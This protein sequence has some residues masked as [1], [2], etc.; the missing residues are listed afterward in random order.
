MKIT[1]ING[2]ARHGSTWNCK[3]LFC[4]ELARYEEIE[5][6]E[7]IMPRDTP[8]LCLGCFNCFFK[9]EQSCP[10]AGQ[11]SPIVA[12]L[13]EA[14]LIVMTSPV[15]ACDITGGLKVLLDHLCYMWMS[16]RPNP[17]MF[18]K[19]ALTIVTTAGAGKKHTTKTMN[20]SLSFWGVK[21][22]FSFQSSVAAMKWEDVK[23]KKK[24]KIEKTVAKQAKKIYKTV[25]NIERI[26]YPLAR[27]FIFKM[28]GAMQKGND[29]NPQDRKHWEEKGWLS[30]AKPY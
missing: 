30:G 6:T 28:M 4:K 14:D 10:H 18:R 2:N 25:H 21:R 3:E 23:P 17:K 16:H 1:I 12:A 22:I 27:G 13:E 19:A 9:G 15:Y 5:V 26:S 7:F 11:I 8:T 20:N 24:A 29:W